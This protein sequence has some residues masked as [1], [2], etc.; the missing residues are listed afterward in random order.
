MGNLTVAAGTYTSA[1]LTISGNPGDVLLTVSADPEAGFAGTAGATIP[2]NQ[3]NIQGTTGSAGSL[4]VPVSVNFVSPLVVTA[5]SS[6]ALDLEFDLA[7][8]AFIVGHV[9]VTT[10]TTVWAVNF[11]G[12]VRHHPI[13]DITRLVLRHAY[14]NVTAVS[15][16][17]SSITINRE[18]P[19]EP[20]VNP[21]TA[22]SGSQSLQILADSTNGTIFYDLDA[23]T[24]TTIHSFSAEAPTIVGK[25][26][27]V[28]ARYQSNGTLVAVRIWSS[29]TFNNVWVSPEG[30]VLHVNTSTD[31][32]TV[33]NELGV[34]VPL[35]VNSNTQFFFRTPWNAVADATPIATGTGFLTAHNFVRGFKV[36]ASVVDPLATP[37]VAQSI[38]IE[39]ARFDGYI[40]GTTTTG[41]TYT[42][43]FH[44]A[45][46][47]YV[48][49]LNYISSSTPNG[50]DS[51]G[52]PITGFK[53]W[54]FTFPTS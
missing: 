48:V 43:N 24:T 32:I 46:D 39:T 10:G 9:P 29:S 45:S 52:N 41:F 36:H 42:R 40:S 2:S 11:N 6:N 53:Y 44:T 17:N 51:S 21:E 7:H 34:G 50:N 23:K 22:V 47:D 1:N 15:S 16:D 5:G 8:P 19:T 27:R 49:P 3:I 4:T 33:Q 30:H 38:D 18:H 35:S 31:V 13:A 26:V 20:P 14:G 37:L 28:A 25:Q 12:P 54:N